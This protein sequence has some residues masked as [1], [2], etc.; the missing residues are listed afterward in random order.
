MR[1]YL[2]NCCFNRPYDNQSQIRIHLETEAKL[3]IQELIKKQELDLV[4]SYMLEYENS[5]NRSLAKKQAIMDFIVQ[6]EAYYV[7]E[8]RIKEAEKIAVSIMQTG[9]KE[10]DAIHVACAILAECKYFI[11]TDDRLLK[12]KNDKVTL[13]APCE[14]IRI[15]EGEN[16]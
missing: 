9:V 12:Y 6:N 4:V 1:I 2:D 8:N 13:I 3:H 11:T 5:K 10:K 16:G 15:L 7:G 14:F